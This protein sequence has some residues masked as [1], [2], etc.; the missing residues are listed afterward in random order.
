M[1]LDP[2]VP[3]GGM[4]VLHGPRASGKTQLALALAVAA[5]QGGLLLGRWRA[6]PARV[7]FIEC[8]T[9]AVTLHGRVVAS[10]QPF[11]TLPIAFLTF[12]S[13][14]NAL[15]LAGSPTSSAALVEAR[16]DD[17]QL[18]IVDSLRKTHSLDENESNTPIQVYSAWRKLFPAATLGFLHHDRKVGM[19]GG[20]SDE[21]FRG[22]SAWLD[23]V[24]TGLHLVRDKSVKG[25]LRAN[26]TFS[27]VRTAEPPPAL[28]LKL[29][30]GTLWPEPAVATSELALRAHLEAH[31]SL[32]KVEAVKWLVEQK[33][34]GRARAY[35]L[36]AAFGL[37]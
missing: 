32:S 19:F 6:T 25:E 33:V 4:F 9:L 18:V 21:A 26:L 16:R 7:L 13:P 14:I 36:A 3:W 11:D 28:A 2:L 24:D 12:D 35:E 27:K 29:G 5:A 31:P 1:L 20:D 34:C 15:A 8:D 22:S 37:E 17:P 30:E 23:D 10:K